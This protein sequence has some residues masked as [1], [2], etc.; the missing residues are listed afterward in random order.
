MR[1]FSVKSEDGSKRRKGGLVVTLVLVFALVAGVCLLAYPTLS[2]WWNQRH[3]SEVVGT[4]CQTVASASADALAAARSA[5]DEYNA[6]LAGKPASY[7]LSDEDMSKYASLLAV[8]DSGVMGWLSIDRIGVK[9]P[10]YHGTSDGVLQMG[11]GHLP[12]SSLPIG[13]PSTHTVLMGHRGLPSAELLSHLDEMRIGDTFSLS[14]LDETLY[15]EVDR[16]IV[17]R[18]PDVSP[19]AI[20][21][22]EDYCTLVTCTPYGVNSHRLLVR[23]HRVDA[24]ASASV[25]DEQAEDAGLGAAVLCGLAAVAVVAVVAGIV[26]VRRRKKARRS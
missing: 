19:L 25:G 26:A 5:A 10:I 1:P 12:G 18:P 20:A 6:S 8:D 22:G 24:P 4:Y 16:I 3:A 15:Y 21:G 9:L 2:N 7:E 17:V 13:G 11:V 14:V 23:G